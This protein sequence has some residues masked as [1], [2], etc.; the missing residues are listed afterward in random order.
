MFDVSVVSESFPPM[1]GI[2]VD[3]TRPL[4]LLVMPEGLQRDALE[5]ALDA[6]G[7]DVATSDSPLHA[8][9]MGLARQPELL[10]L[11]AAVGIGEAAQLALWARG[12]GQSLVRS[13]LFGDVQVADV[14]ALKAAG[15]M[16]ARRPDN[17]DVFATRMAKGLGGVIL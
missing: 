4:A 16:V 15:V 7:M 9:S 8:A 1:D 11:D 12:L 6:Q 2:M 5:W 17:C 14:H 10:L 13:V 3:H